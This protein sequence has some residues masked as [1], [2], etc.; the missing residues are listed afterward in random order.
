ML[1]QERQNLYITATPTPALHNWLEVVVVVVLIVVK[2]SGCC[3]IVNNIFPTWDPTTTTMTDTHLNQVVASQH[4][5]N[6]LLRVRL[7]YT[8]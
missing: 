2:D 3:A 1:N 6:I 5:H 8:Q 4:T 7:L